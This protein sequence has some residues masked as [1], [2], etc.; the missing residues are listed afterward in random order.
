MGQKVTGKSWEDLMR[1][2]IFH[3]LGMTMAGF[4]PPGKQNDQ[5]RDP[6]EG[7]WLQ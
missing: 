7:L 3:P 1:A 4:G 2:K 6:T 5:P